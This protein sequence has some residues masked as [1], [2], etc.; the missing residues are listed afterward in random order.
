MKVRK[1]NSISE[2][3]NLILLFSGARGAFDWS[4]YYKRLPLLPAHA[5][6]PSEPFE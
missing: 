2:K 3:T 4:M 5:E 6:N 1:L